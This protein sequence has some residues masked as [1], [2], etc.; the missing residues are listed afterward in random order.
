MLNCPSDATENEAMS[1]G[2]ALVR[3]ASTTTLGTPTSA[4]FR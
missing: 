1:M 2:I 3:S 4:I